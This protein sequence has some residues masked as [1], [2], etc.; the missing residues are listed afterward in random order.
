MTLLLAVFPFLFVLFAL[1][2][3]LDSM[4]RRITALEEQ[5]RELG[6]PKERP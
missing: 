2:S 1:A 3:W 4:H 5:M 6:P